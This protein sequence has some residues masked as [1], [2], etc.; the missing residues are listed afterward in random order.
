MILE[1]PARP[2]R[3]YRWY[4]LIVVVAWNVTGFTSMAQDRPPGP[5][6]FVL[7]PFIFPAIFMVFSALAF[8]LPF[9]AFGP[10]ARTHLPPDPAIESSSSGGMVGWANAS[11]PLITWKVYPNGIGFLF[12]GIGKGYVP[13]T[14]VTRSRRGLFG[15]CV[16]YHNNQEVRSPLRI[17]SW[18]I[19]RTVES[20][21]GKAHD[22]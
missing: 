20:T 5:E 6:F 16:L 17:P 7:F 3:F 11:A 22:A 2:Y 14:E 4:T 8:K 15:G 19:R 1:A 12:F 9:S 21:I 10:R 18:K 13:F